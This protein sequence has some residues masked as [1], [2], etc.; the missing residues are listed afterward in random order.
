MKHLT[1]LAS[2]AIL[3]LATAIVTAPDQTKVH[4][5][6]QANPFDFETSLQTT[7]NVHDSGTTT[8]THAFSVK[9]LKP[10]IYLKEYSLT[11]SFPQLQE[12]TATNNAQEITPTVSNDSTKTTITVPFPDE[13]VGQGKVRNFNVSYDVPNMAVV[14]G[15]VL[16]VQLP[17]LTSKD[18]YQ[19][20]LVTL[21]TPL[22]FGR[23]VRVKPEPSSVAVQDQQIIT[24]FDQAAHT[25]P[26]SAFFGDRQVY[27]LTLRYNLEN[28]STGAGLAQVALPPDTSF[29]RVNYQSLEP[30]PQELKYDEDGNWL[31]TY[32]LPPNTAQ[33]VYLQ[34]EVLVTLDANSAVPVTPPA[35][36]HTEDKKYWEVNSSQVKNIAE[37]KDSVQDLYDYVVENLNYSYD[38]VQQNSINRRMGAAEALRQP[39]QAVCQEFTDLFIALA[40][41]NGT[42]T[43]RLTGFAYTQNPS[44]RPLSLEQDVLHAW[45][46]YYNYEKNIWQPVDPTWESTTGGVDYFTQF[47][48]NHVVFA[49]NGKSSTTPYPAGAY[50]GSNLTTK[51]VE[52]S[53]AT[54]FPVIKPDLDIIPKSVTVAGI[55][56]PG[57]H[58]LAII[59]KTGQAWYD[60]KVS[61][62]GPEHVQFSQTELNI[63]VLLPFQ[64]LEI[65]LTVLTKEWHSG[66]EVV[67]PYSFTA[68]NQEIV[69]DRHFTALS[70]PTIIKHAS[71]TNLYLGLG[72][73]SAIVILGTWGVLVLGQRRKRPVRR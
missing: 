5:Q 23:A 61:L 56:V 32:E 33:T 71:Q 11:T 60:V 35:S 10:T 16:E 7:Y 66:H 6:E 34:A 8:V 26:I 18:P 20:H 52:Y 27:S 3:L 64:V 55:T 65:P 45:P 30:P 22:K 36:F 73:G 69:N 51:D 17:P 9:N 12:V 25:E 42:P 39:D 49:I 28:N 46:E 44:L 13:V 29:Q 48:L 19:T 53:F 41:A 72:I 24:T 59:N 2:F 58:T 38:T 70:G 40:R 63:P 21:K 50:K 67:V 37:G 62:S 4:A 47:D 57:K 15:Q 31:A 68:L 1:V 14:A 43:R 54:D